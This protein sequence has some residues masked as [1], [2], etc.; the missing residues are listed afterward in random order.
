MAR[1]V[2]RGRE[3]GLDS[4]DASRRLTDWARAILA[5]DEEATISVSELACGEP[6]CGGAETVILI[7]APGRKT[8]A[9]KIKRPMAA[10][11]HEHLIEALA[12]W[13]PT[14]D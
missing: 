4:H 5:L 13:M 3:T 12:P 7:M 2:Y 11:T 9:A 10:V 8:E 6:G 14:R 1:F